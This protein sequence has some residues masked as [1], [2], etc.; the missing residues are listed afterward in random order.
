MTDIRNSLNRY[1][2]VA[3]GLVLVSVSP[4]SAGLVTIGFNGAI[5]SIDDP[6]NLFAG[7]LSID[8]IVDGAYV[9]SHSP[10][11]PPPIPGVPGTFYLFDSVPPSPLG[12]NVQSGGN[13]FSGEDTLNIHITN[14]SEDTGDRFRVV[15]A[16][17]FGFP[18][19]LSAIGPKGSFGVISLTLT[20]PTGL[21]HANEDLIFDA[22]SLDAFAERSGRIV[23]IDQKTGEFVATAMFSIDSML[24]VP[25]PTAITL[26]GVVLA[27]S[28]HQRRRH[29]DR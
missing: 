9:Y 4:A 1:W 27:A 23:I 26:L 6:S 15:D 12:L 22:P 17:Y 2:I 16:S 29:V 7:T 14:D 10:D 20:D 25:E 5:N 8:A 24:L 28:F 3:A 11:V 21:A 19:D 13:T 18:F